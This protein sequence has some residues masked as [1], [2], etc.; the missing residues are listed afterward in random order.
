MPARWTEARVFV[1]CAADRET[2]E[3]ADLELAALRCQAIQIA[4]PAPT[5]L[6]GRIRGLIETGK[7]R[8]EQ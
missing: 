7:Y 4:S 3:C 5:P 6:F 2:A 8:R 1:E